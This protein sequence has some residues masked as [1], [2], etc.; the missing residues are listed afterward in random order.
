[1][2]DLLPRNPTLKQRK[3]FN[4]HQL[5]IKIAA[6]DQIKRMSRE[7]EQSTENDER[8]SRRRRS[9]DSSRDGYSSNDVAPEENE[10]FAGIATEERYQLSST[11]S[12]NRVSRDSSDIVI[13]YYG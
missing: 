12:K 1:M 7:N 8:D 10:Q 3:A 5:Q 6:D 9:F 11:S 2:T 4:K 13:Q